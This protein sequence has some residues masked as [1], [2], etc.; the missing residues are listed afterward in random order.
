MQKITKM[1]AV[2]CQLKSLLLASDRST[3]VCWLHPTS[4]SDQVYPC[5]L[6]EKR[7][8]PSKWNLSSPIGLCKR[9]T[10]TDILFTVTASFKEDIQ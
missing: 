8:I 7:T 4:C 5:V 3:L 10:F 6:T 1:Q 9:L 2:G